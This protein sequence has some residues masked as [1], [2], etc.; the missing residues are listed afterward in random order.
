MAHDAE[1]PGPFTCLIA[2]DSQFARRNIAGIIVKL[3]GTVTGEAANGIEAAE[4]YGKLHPDIVILDI[5]MPQLDGIA[6]LERIMQQ[7]KNAKIVIISALG[8]KEI[9]WQ[10]ITLG[11]KSFI[12]K[13]YAP[14]YAGMI[15]T[16]VLRGGKAGGQP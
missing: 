16:D 13:P 4:L 5:T 6:T 7:D 12:T 8:N 10:A 11:A 9:V 3:G 14:D 1:R 15:I 2:D